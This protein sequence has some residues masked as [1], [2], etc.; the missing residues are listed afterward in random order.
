MEKFTPIKY[1]FPA[2][3]TQVHNLFHCIL[4]PNLIS[5][6]HMYTF[7]DCNQPW[8]KNWV[9]KTKQLDSFQICVDSFEPLLYHSRSNTLI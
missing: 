2:M 3:T 6:T 8:E 1:N 5:K 7:S 9:W 4:Y